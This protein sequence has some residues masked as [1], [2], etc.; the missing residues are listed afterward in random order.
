MTGKQSILEEYIKFK[1]KSIVMGKDI[2]LQEDNYKQIINGYTKRDWQPLFELIPELESERESFERENEYYKWT[3]LMQKLVDII[4]KKVPITCNLDYSE[5][6]IRKFGNDS[7]LTFGELHRYDFSDWDIVDLSNLISMIYR[8]HRFDDCS[9]NIAFQNRLMLRLI[10][11]IERIVESKERSEGKWDDSMLSVSESKSMID[12]LFTDHEGLDHEEYSD[13]DELD[14]EELEPPVSLKPMFHDCESKYCNKN[15]LTLK[16]ALEIVD[17]VVGELS[18]AG[19]QYEESRSMKYD[20]LSALEDFA[21]NKNS[22]KANI[23]QIDIIALYLRK[24]YL[25]AKFYTDIKNSETGDILIPAGRKVPMT[26]LRRVA[27]NHTSLEIELPQLEKE[28]T[29]I[30]R[31]ALDAFDIILRKMNLNDQ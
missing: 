20:I 16:L 30:I 14:D 31:Q 7:D 3:P 12:F 19:N 6:W 2:I 21:D 13:D 28:I 17:D 8:S 9:V 23:L 4:Y 25:G 26:L 18:F 24:Y 15:K 27:S 11:S 10:Q 29:S 5:W 1:R 22:S